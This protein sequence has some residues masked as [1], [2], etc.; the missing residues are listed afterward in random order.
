MLRAT[1]RAVDEGNSAQA[2]TLIEGETETDPGMGHWV[3]GEPRHQQGGGLAPHGFTGGNDTGQAGA[4]GAANVQG[5]AAGDG[6]PLWYRYAQ[7]LA[8]QQGADRE[9]VAGAVEAIE[10]R[11]LGQGL[12]QQFPPRVKLEARSVSR[13]RPGRLAYAMAWS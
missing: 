1:L 8:A 10:I 7:R 12:L 11:I 4:H 3:A 5:I 9:I 13:W 2:V 6:E